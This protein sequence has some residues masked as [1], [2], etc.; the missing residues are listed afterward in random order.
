MHTRT[1]LRDVLKKDHI[2]LSRDYKAGEILYDSP[3]PDYGCCGPDGI[4]MTEQPAT[5]PAQEFPEVSLGPPTPVPTPAPDFRKC[6]AGTPECCV[7][8]AVSPNGPTCEY[9]TQLRPTIL[10]RV[11]NRQMRAQR[12][13]EAPFPGCQLD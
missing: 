12:I 11:K 4:M 6:G 7:F 13:P 10:D 1:L 9:Y 5:T 2:W 8:F 3:F